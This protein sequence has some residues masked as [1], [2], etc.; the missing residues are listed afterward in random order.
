MSELEFSDRQKSTVAFAITLLCAVVILCF[1]GFLLWLAGAFITRFSAIL[2]PLAV[3][4]VLALMLKPYHR[5]LTARFRNRPVLGVLGV[6]LSVLI[7][8]TLGALALSVR[9]A[10]EAMDL[11]AKVP[12]WSQE[13][14]ERME[15]DRPALQQ[16]WEKHNISERL[17][18]TLSDNKEALLQSLARV[19]GIAVDAWTGV[20][21]SVAGLLSWVVLPV[22]LAF[23]LMGKPVTRSQVE[24]LFPFLKE[25]TRKDIT[26]LIFEFIGIVVTFF[27]GQILIA[28]CQGLLFAVGFSIVGLEYGFSLGLILGFLNIIPYLGSM[29]GLSIALPLAFFQDGGGLLKVALVVG[30]FTLVQCIE[31]YVLTPK[32]MGDRTGLHPLAIIVAIFFWGTVFGGITGMV[33]AIPLT[34]FLV[35]LWRLAKTRY[36][37]EWL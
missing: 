13:F 6:Y 9:V 8:L 31:G 33:L 22:Y 23:F 27:R 3:A 16:F 26:Y 34:A 32:I 36:I 25:Q 11:A 37:R 35:V 20:F 30:V 21:R 2:L 14:Q 1:V 28:F 12:V 4:G 10:G 17:Q 7:P 18:K 24:G 15:E 29:V 5:W 19:G